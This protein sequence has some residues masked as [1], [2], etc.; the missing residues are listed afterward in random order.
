MNLFDKLNMILELGKVES[1]Q[2]ASEQTLARGHIVKVNFGPNKWVWGHPPKWVN[3][4]ESDLE[5]WDSDH[6][7]D[8][9]DIVRCNG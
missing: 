5:E 6:E 7:S 3:V 4:S 2:T 8:I 1:F 9:W